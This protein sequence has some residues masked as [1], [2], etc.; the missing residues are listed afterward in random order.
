MP[1]ILE[2][3]PWWGYSRDHG[4]VI[5]DRT[6]PRNKSDRSQD[7]LFFRCRD[8]ATYIDKRS[9]WVAPHYIYASV[10][11]SSLEP[12][13]SEEAALEYRELKSRWAEFEAE[14]HSQYETI[15]SARLRSEQERIQSELAKKAVKAAKPRV[16]K[17][18]AVAKVEAQA[19]EA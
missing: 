1:E 18:D 9:R 12:S 15:E 3:P 4:W 6:I 16:R 2:I 5:I 14:I 8:S 19:S 10:Y 11:I 17:A 13:E 7:F